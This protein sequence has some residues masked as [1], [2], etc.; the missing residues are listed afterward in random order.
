MLN[1][2]PN[3]GWTRPPVVTPPLSHGAPSNF[4]RAR[5]AYVARSMLTT[6]GISLLLVQ[7]VPCL[8]VGS[9][10][11]GIS[12]V[13]LELALWYGLTLAVRTGCRWFRAWWVGLVLVGMLTG[14][15]EIH[16]RTAIIAGCDPK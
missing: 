13:A 12:L 1:T 3:T 8:L 6:L 15:A 9:W 16:R 10:Q 7:L 11:V 5:D 14:C 2:P 4:W